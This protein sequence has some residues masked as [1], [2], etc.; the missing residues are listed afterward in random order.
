MP[1]ESKYANPLEEEF[2]GE[3]DNQSDGDGEKDKEG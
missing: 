2:F 1:K 3:G